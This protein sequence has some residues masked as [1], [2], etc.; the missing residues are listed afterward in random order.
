[1]PAPYS[2]MFLAVESR[3]RGFLPKT[4]FTREN[5]KTAGPGDTRVFESSD[6]GE[7]AVNLGWVGA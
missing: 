2:S 4:T 7:W 6:L 5:L 1:M 3:S